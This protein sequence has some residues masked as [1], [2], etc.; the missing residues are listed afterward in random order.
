MIHELKLKK[1]LLMLHK[2][3]EKFDKFLVKQELYLRRINLIFTS[4]GIIGYEY[5]IVVKKLFDIK[6]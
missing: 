2:I 3:Q 6:H 5:S 4:F 1:M